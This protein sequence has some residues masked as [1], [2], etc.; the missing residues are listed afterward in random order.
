MSQ[1]S[2]FR[3]EIHISVSANPHSSNFQTKLRSFMKH[4]IKNT[5]VEVIINNTNMVAMRTTAVTATLELI[6]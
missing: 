4:G 6:L 1:L 5:P 2:S 3:K